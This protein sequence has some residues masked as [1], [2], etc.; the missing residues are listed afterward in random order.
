MPTETIK[1][2]FPCYAMPHAVWLTP[3]PWPIDNGFIEPTMKLNRPMLEQR[4][5]DPIRALYA[6]HEPAA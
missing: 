3:E 1:R 4:F 2:A 5:A 6:G